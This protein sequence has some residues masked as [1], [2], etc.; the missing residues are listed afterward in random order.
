MLFICM[1]GRS[2]SEG[3]LNSA[4]PSHP[5]HNIHR[6]VASRGDEIYA[7]GVGLALAAV[8]AGYFVY[9][10]CSSIVR[11]VWGDD[12]AVVSTDSGLERDVG[13]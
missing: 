1:S 7:L 10:I 5:E 9:S 3:Y 4:D 11:N 13:D 2:G 6:M 12:A 8:A